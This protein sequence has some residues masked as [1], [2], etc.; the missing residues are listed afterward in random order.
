MI[1]RQLYDRVTYAQAQG[2]KVR[3][4]WLDEERIQDGQQI[5]R[6]R[7]VAMEFNLYD[8]ND[9]YAGTPPLKFVKLIISRAASKRRPGASDWTRVLGLY[10]IVTAF[11][12][13]DLPV[14][15]PITVIPP[16][17]EEPAGWVWQM[18]KA[19]YGTRRASLLFLEFMVDVFEKCGY[20]ALKTSR[21]I[22]YCLLYT[23]DAADE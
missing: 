4:M 12:H 13:A 9:T 5:V 18:K 23:S 17:G 8:R 14:D 6:S 15:E 11:W 7:C 2:K 21:Q 3:S 19:M 10:D 1:E 22:F 20:K 16:R